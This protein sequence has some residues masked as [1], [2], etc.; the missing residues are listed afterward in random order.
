MLVIA[1]ENN[2]GIARLGLAISRKNI[3]TAIKRNQIKRTI[4]E[5]FRLNQEKLEGLDIVV[6]AQKASVEAEKRALKDSLS[7]HWLRITECK[8]Y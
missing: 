4:R 5:S 2:L 1:T 7:N 6:T 3:K 8:K